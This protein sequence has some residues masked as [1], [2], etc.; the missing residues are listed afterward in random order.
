MIVLRL[1]GHTIRRPW[2]STGK[3]F[4]SE[5]V[6]ILLGTSDNEN[7]VK[8]AWASSVSDILSYSRVNLERVER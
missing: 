4:C 2:H 3:Y 7:Y 6:A 5:V 8:T 1:F